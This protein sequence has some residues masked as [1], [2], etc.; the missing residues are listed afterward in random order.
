MHV[1]DGAA[2]HSRYGIGV[3]LI[4]PHGG[5][6]PRSHRLVFTD[7]YLTM[8]NIIEYK[9]CILA[10]EATLKLGIRQMEIFSDSNLVISQI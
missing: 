6:I 9:A 7:R 4:S 5:H 8:N 3:L 1:L 2:N 10:L